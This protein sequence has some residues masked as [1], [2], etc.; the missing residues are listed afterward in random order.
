MKNVWKLHGLLISPSKRNSVF[1]INYKQWQNIIVFKR[2]ISTN[3]VLLLWPNEIMGNLKCQIEDKY[4]YHSERIK[5]GNVNNKRQFN[6]CTLDNNIVINAQ[7]LNKLS[8][9]N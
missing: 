6:L 1:N 4:E 8:L 3:S 7:Q 9:S 5:F 2:T